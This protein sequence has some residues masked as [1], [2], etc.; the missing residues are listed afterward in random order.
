MTPDAQ[1]VTRFLNSFTDPEQFRTYCQGQGIK[2]RVGC[3]HQCLLATAIESATGV[4][5]SMG[6]WD[7]N[8]RAGGRNIP[9][10]ALMRD[11]IYAFDGRRW[12]ELIGQPTP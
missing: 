10:T 11:I 2:A 3:P 8:L 7:W 1:K 4:A 9:T 5:V 6:A 12:P